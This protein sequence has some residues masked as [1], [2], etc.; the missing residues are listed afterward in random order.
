M[1]MK[2]SA[3]TSSCCGSS[4][5]GIDAAF[6]NLLNLLLMDLESKYK[7]ELT[8][9]P[10]I[11][12]A[13]KQ[14]ADFTGTTVEELVSTILESVLFAKAGKPRITGPKN[15]GGQELKTVTGPTNWDRL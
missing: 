14:E 4:L 3:K 11:N 1:R 6:F 7:L 10:E 5:V 2:D 9:T 13:L 15:I 8:I 12:K